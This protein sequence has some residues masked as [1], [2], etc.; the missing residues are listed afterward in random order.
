M[1]EHVNILIWDDF[2]VSAFFAFL[3]NALA[4]PTHPQK[5]KKKVL[6]SDTMGELLSYHTD[7]SVFYSKDN[8]L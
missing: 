3:P 6:V 8:Y 7:L 2:S 1:L 4:L 5:K